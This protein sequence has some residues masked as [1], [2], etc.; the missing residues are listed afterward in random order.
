MTDHSENVYYCLVYCPREDMDDG[1]EF[2]GIFGNSP[3]QRELLEKTV[4]NF[5]E[6]KSRS[7]KLKSD[8]SIL[9]QPFVKQ[10]GRNELENLSLVD[11]DGEVLLV[12]TKA[13]DVD[14]QV[15]DAL[16]QPTP[17]SLNLCRIISFPPDYFEDPLP[18]EV[19]DRWDAV[20]PY[21]T[22]G[23]DSFLFG[24][25]VATYVSMADARAHALAECQKRTDPKNGKDSDVLNMDDRFWLSATT[26]EGRLRHI[27]V[28]GKWRRRRATGKWVHG[29]MR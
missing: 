24:G 5:C 14:Q 29:K 7:L 17:Q 19:E 13:A 27:I 1:E 22:P 9:D 6:E 4:R 21:I 12:I 20:T 18:E 10:E 16:N 3:E 8:N 15:T 11:E 2:G 23:H 25:L 26:E 28:V